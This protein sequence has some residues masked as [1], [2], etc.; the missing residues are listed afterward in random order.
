M[1]F[2]RPFLLILT[3]DMDKY[4]KI[5]RL[6]LERAPLNYCSK[7]AKFEGD[8]LK[9]DEGIPPQSLACVQTPPPLRKNRE[10]G[11]GGEWGRMHTGYSKSRNFTD[12]GAHS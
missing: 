1:V 10:K 12:A 11:K 5:R 7:I 6:L 2:N 3:F 4:T 8:L 9:T